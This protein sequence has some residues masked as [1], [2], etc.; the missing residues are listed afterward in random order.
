MSVKGD[1]ELVV[2]TCMRRRAGTSAASFS[3]SGM[4]A[5]E[6]A[7]G[8]VRPAADEGG[9][10][11]AWSPSALRGLVQLSVFTETASFA[12]RA[13]SSLDSFRSW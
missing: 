8:R 13:G 10:A 1:R 3:A 11:G 4:S 9:V 2:D 12:S 5:G 6:P 7:G